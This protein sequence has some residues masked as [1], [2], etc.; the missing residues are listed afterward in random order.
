MFAVWSSA[1]LCAAG[2][3]WALLAVWLLSCCLAPA[4]CRAQAAEFRLAK[5]T[6]RRATLRCELQRNLIIV[7]ARL[8]GQGPYNFLLD[9][10][11][12]QSIIT[13]PALSAALHLRHGLRFEI[14]GAG[15]GSGLEAYRTDSVRVELPGVVAP[16][17]TF[18][19]LS[20]D[21]LDLSG[22]IGM[23]IH[24]ILGGEL[25]RSFVVEVKPTQQRLYLHDPVRFRPPVRRRW[26]AVPFVLQNGKPY[27]TAEVRVTDALRLPLKL[28]LDTGA[29]HALSLETSS[30]ARLE[31]PA[32]HLRSQLGRGLNGNINGYL[33]RV[34]TL[35][36]GRYQLPAP[37][38][39]FPD[40]AEV[41]NRAEVPRNG[42]LGFELLKRFDFIIDYSRLQLLVRPNGLFRD[43]FEHDMSG[44]DLLATGPDYRR[45]LVLKVVP[46]SPAA[47]AGLCPGDE[48]LLVNMLPAYSYS[49]TQLSRLLHSADGR[50]LSIIVQ[51]PGGELFTTTLCLK[52]QI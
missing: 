13:D 49:L 34:R 35:Q 47:L 16:A 50:R 45:Y 48:L 12:N 18:I 9:T 14:V 3:R 37:L 41:Q 28:V 1:L 6:A 30:N 29:G 46:D 20:A 25:F 10:G 23:P 19:V 27:L 36:L 17:L 51:R 21:V 31:V 26:A 11:V 43:P 33:G 24:G 22:Y 7:G 39:S 40:A 44:L 38:T 15:E 8:N 32:H 5:A 4:P 52:R 2:I 42:N